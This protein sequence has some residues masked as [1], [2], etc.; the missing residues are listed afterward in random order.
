MH[1]WLDG[2]WIC[3]ASF[4]PST[5]TSPISMGLDSGHACFI[6]ADLPLQDMKPGTWNGGSAVRICPNQQ[7]G[8]PTL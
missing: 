1:A 2:S 7:P 8:P 4:A 3:T 5:K 6:V